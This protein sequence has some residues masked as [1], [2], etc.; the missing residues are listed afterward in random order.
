M[1]T[2]K[3]NKIMNTPCLL[4]KCGFLLGLIA[5]YDQSHASD[6]EQLL[7][8]EVT[9]DGVHSISHQQLVDFGLE[10]NGEPL[11]RL[12]IFNQ[13]KTIPVELI[14]STV[15]PL[16]FGQGASIRF[17]GEALDTLYTDTNV[18]TLAL[19]D[20]AANTEQNLV[21]QEAIE[22]P[23]RVP[24]TSSYLVTKK[25]APQVNYSFAS[26]DQTDPWYAA[27]VLAL[28]E[29]GSETI[30][31]E[32][33]DYVPGGNSGSA[34]A[35]LSVNMWGGTDMPGSKDDHHVRVS[36]NNQEVIDEVF[37][38]FS[39][40]NVSVPIT[41]LQVGNNRVRVDLPL[42]QGFDFESVNIDEISMT[43]PRAF[44]AIN[45]ALSF[46]SGGAKF[47][48]SGFTST[49]VNV[50]RE[51][52]GSVTRLVNA[53]TTGRCTP[54]QARCSVRFGGA[55]RLSKYY[56][57]AVDKM[58]TPTFAYVVDQQDIHSGSAD[59]LIITHPDFIAQDNEV[60]HLANLARQIEAQDN[61]FDKVAVVDVEQI[62]AQFGN[63]IYDPQ[64]IRDY[65]KFANQNRN[66]RTVLLVGGDVYDYRGYENQQARSFIPSI[67]V[68]TDDLI[69]FAPVDAK[70]VDLDDDNIPDLPIGRLPVRT[71]SELST[72]INKRM[73]YLERDYKNSVL[74]A[75]D[76]FDELE[77]YNFQTD[78]ENLRQQYFQNK[79]VTTAYLDDLSVREARFKII[80]QINQGQ[81]LT[82]FFG[83]SSTSQWTFDGMFNGSD[84][85]RLNNIDRPT[86]VTQW[87]CWNTYYVNPN[88][89]SMGHRFLME[90]NR[91]AVAVM[92]ATTLTR[93]SNERLLAN[94][95]FRRL[96]NGESLGEA[97]TNGKKDFAKL[98]PQALDVILGWTLLGPPEL[99]L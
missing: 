75:A 4:L 9:Q 85:T 7:N 77:Q 86:I 41:N 83:H 11:N 32:L 80:D 97:I 20:E 38:G 95:V 37:D 1:L 99:T 59:Y 68:P 58:L 52:N 34:G 82:S 21:T 94:Y 2:T 47:R 84:A 26:P 15:D 8:L 93:A 50:Y 31:L 70:Y 65:I 40:R 13:G 53:Q 79:D 71:V 98:R 18:Y 96:T 66:T 88:E 24:F 14:G 72:L 39:Q 90:G 30:T 61:G 54:E 33:D 73:A 17:I 81:S 76:G 51:S 56:V 48:V 60:D 10:L 64:A 23:S 67:Y 27:R 22:L 78:A 44:D 91:G 28:R 45:E 12:V 89:D 29:P 3:L 74:F 6:Y 19:L 87:G 63:N 42:D 49:D 43:Y 25:F 69:N 55:G 62:Y 35:R 36:F 5:A 92:G 46:N 57:S 16:L